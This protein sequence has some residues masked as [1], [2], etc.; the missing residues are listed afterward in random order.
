MDKKYIAILR[1]LSTRDSLWKHPNDLAY[2]LFKHLSKEH[3]GEISEED[4][5]TL[6]KECD[7]P[8][9]FIVKLKTRID[10]IKVPA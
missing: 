10:S 9:E 1:N 8:N 7:R 6:I 5:K 4:I 3:Q 2:T